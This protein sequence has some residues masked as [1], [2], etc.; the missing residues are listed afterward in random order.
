MTFFCYPFIILGL[1]VQYFRGKLSIITKAKLKVPTYQNQITL[2]DP[3]LR[4]I[5]NF[6]S[7]CNAGI[8]FA[9]LYPGNL[10]CFHV[11][12]I[13]KMLLRIT[14]LY[15]QFTNSF[16]K[17]CYQIV[18]S[19]ISHS[20]IFEKKIENIS[21]KFAIENFVLSF[22]EYYLCSANDCAQVRD[23]DFVLGI[24]GTRN[25]LNAFGLIFGI[26]T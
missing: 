7:M 22:Q 18:V 3:F 11:A 4:Y 9:K 10:T 20:A 1:L 12:N 2:W 17:Y 26:H 24:N 13:G 21:G 14:P 5:G 15:S 6:L 25:I 16:S 23:I 19:W 8:Y